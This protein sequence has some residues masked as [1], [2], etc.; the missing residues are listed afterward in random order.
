MAMAKPDLA[1][2]ILGSNTFRIA[3]YQYQREVL[4]TNSFAGKS[5]ILQQALDH[6]SVA[7]GPP[8]FLDGMAK[9]DLAVT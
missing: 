8:E 1:W 4:D 9:P 7:I 5:M 2:L 6:F 3:A